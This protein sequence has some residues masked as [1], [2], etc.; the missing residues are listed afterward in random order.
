MHVIYGTPFP[1]LTSTDPFFAELVERATKLICTT[2]E[3]DALAAEVGI[4]SS[5]AGGDRWHGGAP[6]RLDRIGVRAHFR[7]VPAGVRRHQSRGAGGVSG[8]VIT[9][10]KN[11]PLAFQP[12]LAVLR[13][14]S[15]RS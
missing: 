11:S 9:P 14:I 13:S 3:Y 6:V 2:G 5:A 1:R 7:H 4:G 15:A 12:A 8:V 10:H